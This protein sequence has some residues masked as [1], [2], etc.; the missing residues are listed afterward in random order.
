MSFE[1]Q[2]HDHRTEGCAFVAV[3]ERMVPRNAEGIRRRKRSKVSF[4][5]GDIC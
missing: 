1:T 3:D 4:A 5:I 2:K